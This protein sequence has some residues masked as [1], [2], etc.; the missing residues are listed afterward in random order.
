MS[1]TTID[2]DFVFDGPPGPTGPRFIDTVLTENGN[3]CGV[4][5]WFDR[6]DGTWALVVSI[7]AGDVRTGP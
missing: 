6:G 5:E 7:R 1:E 3:G 4:G 2:V